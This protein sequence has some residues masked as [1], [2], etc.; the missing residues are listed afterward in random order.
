MSKDDNELQTGKDINLE[1]EMTLLRHEFYVPDDKLRVPTD[2]EVINFIKERYRKLDKR[3][4]LRK[5]YAYLAG[6]IE[7]M[8]DFGASSRELITPPLLEMG[9]IPLNPVTIEEKKTGLPPRETL[10]KLN[11]LKWERDWEGFRKL[12]GRVRQIDTNLIRHASSLI[13]LHIPESEPA[14]EQEM[15]LAA[16]NREMKKFLSKIDK[17]DT[18]AQEL[19]MQ[20]FLKTIPKRVLPKIFEAM[21]GCKA[22]GGTSSEIQI[23]ANEKIPVLFVCSKKGINTFNSTWVLD[24]IMAMGKI[25]ENFD[26][27]LKF[28]RENI[29][30]IRE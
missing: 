16:L 22:T 14:I 13:I 1:K 10:K 11:E 26:S 21:S 25:F 3:L 30:K 8:G 18:K 24:A 20:I 12:A 7:T 6:P 27:M 9:I 15:L 28:L 5:V 29:D 2:G 23:A 17:E 4:K 19:A